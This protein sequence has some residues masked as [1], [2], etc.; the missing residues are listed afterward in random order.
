MQPKATGGSSKLI[1]ASKPI[2]KKR[3]MSEIMLQR[4]LSSSSLLKQAAAAAQAQQSE[5]NKPKSVRFS[6]SSRRRS[7]SSISSSGLVSPPEAS[8]KKKKKHI[9]FN[10]QVEQCIAIDAKGDDEDEP[11]KYASHN[12]SDSDWDDGGFLMTRRNSKRKLPALHRE[13]LTRRASLGAESKTIA[14]LPSTTLKYGEDASDIPEIS[15]KLSNGFWNASKF[16]SSPSQEAPRPVNRSLRML[17]GDDEGE[18]EDGLDPQPPSVFT[19]CKDLRKAHER[20]RSG[21]SSNDS[22]DSTCERP[23]QS[24]S[25]PVDLAKA[26]AA[27]NTTRTN[28]TE[29]KIAS[30]NS[31]ETSKPLEVSQDVE[32]ESSSKLP[33]PHH[34]GTL[35]K[36]LSS[37]VN[38][39]RIKIDRNGLRIHWEGDRPEAEVELTSSRLSNQHTHRLGN[40]KFGPQT[41]KRI[42]HQTSEVLDMSYPIADLLKYRLAPSAPSGSFENMQSKALNSGKQHS[43]PASFQ[44]QAASEVPSLF[45]EDETVDSKDSTSDQVIHIA[46]ERNYSASLIISTGGRLP[47]ACIPASDALLEL[48]ECI[49]DEDAGLN[50]KQSL[51][52]IVNGALLGSELGIHWKVD[53]LNKTEEVD[54]DPSDSNTPARAFSSDGQS[55]D[56]MDEDEAMNDYS[57]SESD[58]GSSQSPYHDIFTAADHEFDSRQGLIAP[59]L[60]SMRQALVD[61]VMEEFWVVFNPSWEIWVKECGSGSSDSSNGQASSISPDVASLQPGQR[62]RQ[63]GDEEPEDNNRNDPRK[64]RRPLGPNSGPDSANRFACPFRKHDARR[65]SM[66]SHRVCALSHWETIARVKYVGNFPS[67]AF[68]SVR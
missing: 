8:K 53:C 57:S 22:N 61:R 24:V 11:E 17:P 41:T 50:I 25:D 45:Q 62:K 38:K 65:Y 7:V 9:H 35:S 55:N 31:S 66:Q 2:L 3:N 63:R 27:L 18:D 21:D 51:E 16:C 30:N 12:C 4:S 5:Y 54:E 49:T 13:R 19:K 44:V 36:L 59:V 34:F 29:I 1:L 10:E 43:L 20:Q 48:D 60:D 33:E 40:P 14:M 42:A 28:I 39:T 23:I 15:M 26:A 58:T 46:D 52:P 56:D 67:E 47:S 6:C 32:S 68:P 37:V 64:P